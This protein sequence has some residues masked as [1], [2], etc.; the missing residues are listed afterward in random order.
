MISNLLPPGSVCPCSRHA[1]FWFFEEEGGGLLCQRWHFGAHWNGQSDHWG[2]TIFGIRLGIKKWYPVE[3]TCWV[4]LTSHAMCRDLIRILTFIWGVLNCYDLYGR[5]LKWW[6][7]PFH[8]P[9]WSLLVGK[10]NGCWGNRTTILGKPPYDMIISCCPWCWD[11]F[12][13]HEG[14]LEDH[15]I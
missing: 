15:P 5:F 13:Q 8:T 6:Y 7:P 10:N 11:N 9:K 14:Y 1:D 2:W 4:L 12:S 3:E